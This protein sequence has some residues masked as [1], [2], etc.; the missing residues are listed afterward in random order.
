MLKVPRFVIADSPVFRC[1]ADGPKGSASIAA[2]GLGSNAY[3]WT[4]WVKVAAEML[5]AEG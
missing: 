4:G 3:R 1:D 2:I 5:I